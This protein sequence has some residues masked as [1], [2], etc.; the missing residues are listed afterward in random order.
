ML[1]Q[2]SIKGRMYIIIA[3]TLALFV[4]MVGFSINSSKN[5]RDLAVEKTRSIM[6]EDQKE[7][8]KT[9]THAAAIIIGHWLETVSEDNLKTELIQKAVDDFRFEQDSSGYIFVFQKTTNISLPPIKSLQGKDLIDL[10]D[11]NGVHLIK[12]LWDVSQKGGG[13]VE[14]VWS[15]PGAGEV[16]KISYAEMIPGTDFWIGAGVYLDNIQDSTA[17]MADQIDDKVTSMT[18]RMVVVSGIFFL[19]IASLCLVIVSNISNS[20]QYMIAS[21]KDIAEGE[22][23]LTKRIKLDSRDELGE[24][25]KWFNV[26][27][28]KLQGIIK[29]LMME[30]SVVDNSSA[31]LA[32]IAGAMSK[33]AEDTHTKAEMVSAAAEEMTSSFAAITTAMEETATNASMIAAASEE[34]NST[35]KEISVSTEKACKISNDAARKTTDTE[36]IMED[37]SRA[38]QAIGTITETINEISDQTNL[39]ALNATIEAARAGEAGKGFVV[40]ANEIK[41]LASQ[42]ARSTKEIRSQIENVQKTSVTTVKSIKEVTSVIQTVSEIVSTISAALTE[43]SSTSLEVAGN[44]ERLSTGIQDINENVSQS[45]LVIGQITSQIIGVSQ[46]SD[47]IANSS[48][49][50][51]N[52]A[53]QLKEM[54]VSVKKIVGTFKI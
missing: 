49:K 48:V 19:C 50:V 20:L 8:I 35:V 45:S 21:F 1:K 9:A 41:E 31:E 2:F 40:V 27:L 43:Q 14:Y 23:D 29:Q 6:L 25:G 28:G 36:I 33:G 12:E 54:A 47:G 52:S 4:T 37:L 11:K 46:S 42:T 3:A 32:E 51:T 22:G 26:F 16:S 5:A 30:S 44:I 24:L 13:F 10:K 34:M 39:L 17:S 18:I 38:V 7:K 53:D 15:K